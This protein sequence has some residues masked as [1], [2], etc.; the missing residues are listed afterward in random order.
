M[1]R[2]LRFCV[3]QHIYGVFCESV[4]VHDVHEERVRRA[5]S[6]KRGRT[7]LLMHKERVRRAMNEKR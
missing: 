4:V 7:E 6:E 1:A 2:N 5:M 3:H